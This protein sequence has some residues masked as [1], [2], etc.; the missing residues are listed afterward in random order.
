MFEYTGYHDKIVIV[1]PIHGEFEKRLSDH[2]SKRK[3]Q[4]CKLCSSINQTENA[5]VYYTTDDLEAINS[6]IF[7]NY[8][9]YPEQEPFTG[10]SKVQIKCP[11][12]G[13]FLQT[14]YSHKAGH[15]CNKCSYLIRSSKRKALNCRGFTTLLHAKAFRL[16][17]PYEDFHCTLYLVRLKKGEE[18]FLKIGITSTSIA[19]RFQTLPYDLTEELVLSLP[20]EV[21]FTTESSIL[22]QFSKYAYKPLERFGGYTECFSIECLSEIKNVL[23]ARNGQ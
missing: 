13:I 23:L 19:K 20:L 10:R 3:P 9:T 5:K 1:C 2:I 14:Y 6:S 17:I 12:H 7:E 8:F 4:G 21:A 11:T 15:H 18:D 22:S 16:G